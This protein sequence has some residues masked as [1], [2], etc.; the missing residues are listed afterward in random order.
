MD[1]KVWRRE[2]LENGLQEVTIHGFIG[3]QAGKLSDFHGDPTD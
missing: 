1:L 3:I 2:L